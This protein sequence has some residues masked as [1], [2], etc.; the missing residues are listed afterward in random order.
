MR[1]VVLFVLLPLGLMG[2]TGDTPTK[3]GLDIY[4]CDV[5]GGA[6]TL[7]VTPAGES[8][9]V[10]SGWPGDRDPDRI[11]K[12]A[13]QV[14]GLK[15]IDHYITTHWH[16]DHF[17]G[18]GRLAELI[19]VMSYYDHGFP[20]PPASDIPPALVEAYKKVAG[21]RNRALKPGDEIRLK[22]V[23]GIPGLTLRCLAAHGIVLGEKAGAPQ[24]RE[25]SAAPRHEEKPMDPSDNARSL[26]FVLKFGDWEFFDAGDLTWNVEHKLV[27]PKNLAGGVDVYQVTHHGADASNNPALLAALRPRVA[28]MNNG[29]RKGG[30]PEAVKTIR[31]SSD[32]QAFFAVHRN[33]QTGDNAA[34]ELTANDA[35]QCGGEFIKL[36]VAPDSK[37]YSVTVPSKGT[38]KTFR[39]SP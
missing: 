22:Q 5:E 39:T 29:A 4:W 25:C 23:S 6:A 20:E 2:A 32:L 36:T 18:I 19:P 15:Q 7:I 34:P 33:V 17:G 35:E 38:V 3:R 27:C 10:D 16:T 1:K 11:A 31:A 21:G 14:A 8:I 9:L 28:I 26:A 12:I 24:I 30:S 37:S 13:K